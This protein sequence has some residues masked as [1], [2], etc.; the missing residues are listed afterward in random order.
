MYDARFTCVLV[1][2][3][4][5]RVHAGEAGGDVGTGEVARDPLD[6]SRG[7]DRRRRGRTCVRR[8]PIALLTSILARSS[9]IDLEA[10]VRTVQRGR[11]RPGST[12]RWRRP[13]RSHWKSLTAASVRARA[14]ASWAAGAPPL[15]A[16]HDDTT[17]SFC[18]ARLAESSELSGPERS[19]YC[20]C[21]WQRAEPVAHT[22][23]G[24]DHQREE[25][26][27]E[28]EQQLGAEAQPR[29][30]RLSSLQASQLELHPYPPAPNLGS[31]T[32]SQNCDERATPQVA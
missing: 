4:F 7:G 1:L 17:L 13:A 8:R 5:E 29:H 21:A 2:R 18:R 27:E 20:S 11:S 26:D 9:G 22:R 25:R 19:P 31:E 16:N 12:R 14:W 15:A 10:L 23:G 6:R 28:D 30:E 32:R 3:A 24:D